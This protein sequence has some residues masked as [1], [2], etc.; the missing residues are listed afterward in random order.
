[1]KP[2]TLVTHIVTDKDH[3]KHIGIVCEIT[4]TE[5]MS[6]AVTVDYW[7]R[8]IKP[9]GSPSDGLTRHSYNE[10]KEKPNE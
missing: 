8:W 7:V 9:D 6:G 10:L 2:G 4:T 1:M 3:D 5:R